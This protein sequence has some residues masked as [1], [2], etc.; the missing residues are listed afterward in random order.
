MTKEEAERILDALRQSERSAR[1]MQEKEEK[2][3]QFMI[4]KNW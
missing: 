3:T 2:S 4:E 1:D